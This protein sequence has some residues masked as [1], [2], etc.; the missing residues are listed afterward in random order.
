MA[1]RSEYRIEH[2]RELDGVKSKRAAI[3]KFFRNAVEHETVREN[4]DPHLAGSGCAMQASDG[5]NSCDPTIFHGSANPHAP[6]AKFQQFEHIRLGDLGIK[7]YLL[8]RAGDVALHN[9]TGFRD[10]SSVRHI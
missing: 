9:Q 6:K 2:M 8:R 3:E 7:R 5:R 10:F 4:N 1:L